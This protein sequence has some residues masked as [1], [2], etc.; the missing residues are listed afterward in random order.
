MYLDASD[1]QAMQILELTNPNCL[2]IEDSPMIL[3]QYEVLLKQLKINY[4]SFKDG[5]TA[6][7]ALRKAVENNIKLDFMIIDLMLPGVSG[8]N[9]LNY[10][11]THDLLKDV[12]LLVCTS[13]CERERVLSVLKSYKPTHFLLKPV[14][15]NKFLA[16]AKTI[17][18]P[19]QKK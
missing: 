9:I 19:Y 2:I 12:P 14:D 15:S 4:I 13:V 7:E 6:L 1:D 11:K 8:T 17:L 3:R 18:K 5:R 10:I 16:I